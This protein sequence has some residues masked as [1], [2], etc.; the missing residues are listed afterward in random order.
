L[1]GVGLREEEE[2]DK[3]NSRNDKKVFGECLKNPLNPPFRKGEDE[4]FF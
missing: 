1:F 4:V 3:Y 2:E